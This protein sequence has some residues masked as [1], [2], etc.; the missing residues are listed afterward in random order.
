MTPTTTA[1]ST[2]GNRVWSRR[3][4]NIS[5]RVIA[6][7]PIAGHCHSPGEVSAWRASVSTPSP[8]VDTSKTFGSWLDRIKTAAAVV[9]PVSTGSERRY[10]TLPRRSRP[11]R[12]RNT[13]TNK[14]SRAA[15]AMYSGEPGV[16]NGSSAPK[17]KR[18]VRATGPVCR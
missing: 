15:R 10:A 6:A 11:S 2:P 5:T 16:D 12:I 17:A 13:P 7:K 4:P 14:A 3:P 18:A 9:K 1:T 8:S